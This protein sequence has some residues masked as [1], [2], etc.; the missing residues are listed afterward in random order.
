MI[1][2]PTEFINLI[3]PKLSPDL[4]NPF[5]KSTELFSLA[6]NPSNVQDLKR[7]TLDII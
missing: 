2:I 1:T 6:I 4:S 7:I 5:K 3:A